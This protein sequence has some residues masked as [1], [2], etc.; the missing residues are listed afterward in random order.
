VRLLH[1]VVAGGLAIALAGCGL[2]ANGLLEGD[3][4]E[5]QNDAAAP[6]LDGTVGNDDANGSSDVTIPPAD[7][8]PGSNEDSGGEDATVADAGSGG[9]AMSGDSGGADTGTVDSGTDAGFDSGVDSGTGV[10]SGIDSGVDSGEDAG[11]DACVGSCTVSQVPTGWA[12]AEYAETSRPACSTGYGSPQDVLEGPT[13]TPATCGCA[14]DVTTPGNCETGNFTV[15]VDG[16]TAGC[17]SLPVTSPANGG[18]CSPATDNYTPSTKPKMMVDPVGYTA[19]SCTAEPSVTIPAVT[20]TGQGR[21]CTST[22]SENG[23][24]PNGGSCVDPPTG[25]TLCIA[26]TGTQ[27]CPAGFTVSHTVGSGIDDTRACTACT[28]GGAK[29]TCGKQTLTLYTN[30]A[31]T[32]GGET[33]QAN[34]KCNNFPVTTGATPTY[35]AYEYAADVDGEGCPPSPVSA[36]GGV[37]LTGIV[38]VCCP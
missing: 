36:T 15:N 22:G 28:C 33:V 31:C 38:T 37:T 26:Q 23:A 35:V 5:A 14:C 2:D 21:I 1:L 18:A 30:T 3:A 19:G 4:G 10:D 13:G 7:S 27:T 16:L 11:D 24:C 29:A 32:T 12:I 17:S 8:G 20:Y 25:F 9:D 6:T 34:D